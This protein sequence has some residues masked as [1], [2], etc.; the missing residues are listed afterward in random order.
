MVSLRRH[1]ILAEKR[2]VQKEVRF[3]D[4]S[5]IA[6]AHKLLEGRASQILQKQELAQQVRA[7]IAEMGDLDREMLLLRHVEELT[8]QE[9]AALL[10]I[11]TSTASQRYGRALIRLR[12]KLIS[13]GILGD[14]V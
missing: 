7:T 14:A 10:E 13:I 3:P 2:N 8:N 12:D 6:L 5:S 11:D 9:I 1:H 4:H